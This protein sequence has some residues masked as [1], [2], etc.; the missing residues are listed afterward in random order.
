MSPKDQIK[1]FAIKTEKELE[2]SWDTLA[3]L[4]ERTFNNPDDLAMFQYK[5]ASILFNISGEY[6][7]ILYQKKALIKNQK[8]LKQ[9]DFKNQYKD[10]DNALSFLKCLIYTGKSLGD[11]FVWLFYQSEPNHLAEHHKRPKNTLLIPR[12]VGGQGEVKFIQNIKIIPDHILLYHGITN[13][14]TIGDYSVFNLNTAKLSGIGELKAGKVVGNNLTLNLTILG[15][16]SRAEDFE[17]LSKK[18]SEPKKNNGT[19]VLPDANRYKK[20]LDEIANSFKYLN[21]DQ[22]GHE[23]FHI[24]SERSKLE[25]VA[26]LV[27]TKSQNNLEYRIVNKGMIICC[28]YCKGESL[29]KRWFNTDTSNLPISE[30]REDVSKIIIPDSKFNAIKFGYVFYDNNDKPKINPSSKPLFW[31]NLNLKTLKKI[32]FSDV[33]I[34]TIYNPAF[35]LETLKEIGLEFEFDERHKK[36]ML[37]KKIDNKIISADGIQ[38]YLDLIMSHLHD[39]DSIKNTISKALLFIEEKQKETGGEIRADIIMMTK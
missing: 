31:Q 19:S 34:F 1:E 8:K 11:A 15:H 10:F 12:N 33:R 30:M 24:Y 28:H 37:V 22:G 38:F 27:E 2:L 5:L 23:E 18:N 29:Y 36:Y 4:K 14:L 16:K 7:K 32:Y 26:E 13:I 6:N 25:N 35:L 20:Q 39:E 21:K 3:S 9:I 17:K